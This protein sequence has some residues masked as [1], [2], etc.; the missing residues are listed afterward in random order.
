MAKV[1][2]GSSNISMPP[3][4]LNDPQEE[5][6]GL[7]NPETGFSD[8]T[9]KKP[10]IVSKELFEA[11]NEARKVLTEAEQKAQQLVTEAEDKAKDIIAQAEEEAARMKEQARQEGFAQGSHESADKYTQMILEHSQRLEKKESEVAN[12]VLKLSMAIAK[13]IIGNTL[14]AQPET[15]VE[16]AKNHLVSVKQRREVFLCVS[17]S[18]LEMLRTHK[19]ALLDQLG[20][21][22]EIEIRADDN[23]SPGSMLIET[24][25]GSIDAKLETQLNIIEQKLMS[26]TKGH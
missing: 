1:I 20:R 2:K 10:A 14:Q 21:A 4:D 16:M 23:L 3:A 18:D 13:K 24:E 17:S 22:K 26:Q 12:Q 15:I 8:V 5:E 6:T 25:A 19:R 7:I 9:R 11:N